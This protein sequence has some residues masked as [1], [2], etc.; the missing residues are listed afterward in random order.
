MSFRIWKKGEGPAGPPARDVSRAA[1]GA[2][3][4]PPD[5]VAA[6]GSRI[7]TMALVAAATLAL[8][9]LLDRVFSGVR[10]GS[11]AMLWLIGVAGAIAASLVMAWI[12]GRQM[13]DSEKLLDAALVYEVVMG[14]FLSVNIHASAV[15]DAVPRGWSAVAVWT[16]AYPLIVPATRG[17]V[18]LATVATAVMDPL[19]LVVQVAAGN[20][21][22]PA[23][24]VWLMFLPTAVAAIA[25]IV[26]SGI[27]Y[28]MNVE[29][30][31]GH[32]MGSY[33]LEELLGSGGMGEVW[34]ASH[35]LLARSA[36]IKLI[37]PDSSGSDG[38]E[39][40]K[41]FE[42]EVQAAA[43]LQSPH[44]VNIYDFGTTEDGTFYYVMELLEG[45][46][47]ETLVARF[48]PVPAER[49]VHILI[50]ACHSLAEAHQGG[51]IHRDV[52]PANIYVCR[53]GLEW[54]FVKILDF[55]LVKNT[56]TETNERQLTRAGVLAG[57]PGYMAPEMGMGT[58]DL[59]WRAD[60]YALGA[61][62]YWLVTG[63][64]L[65]DP[66]RPA[67]QIIMDHVQKVPLPP[68]RRTSNFVPPRLEEILMSCLQKDPNNRPQTM[69]ELA[70][71]LRT[72]PLEREWTDDRARRWWLAH[73]REAQDVVVDKA[74]EAKAST[75]AQVRAGAV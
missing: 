43:G 47:V 8:F 42:R 24:A 29:A 41:R 11:S 46:D 59:D 65:F 21:A 1:S 15:T 4:L 52:K 66:K 25:A 28:Q 30:E 20:P 13:L 6:S 26:V 9:A 39:S 67:M 7:T 12:S 48:G 74:A 5:L 71:S 69:Q 70:A 38:R 58:A 40:I 51:L 49:V 10:P 44:T 33:H 45:F 36:A 34:K 53:Y 14:L 2:A 18:I 22:P 60:I 63:E 56:A 3:V 57:T 31:K 54:D 64:T 72:V 32:E 27:V 50:Q 73:A 19:G 62:G 37:R 23:P 35:R 16:L 75:P 61:V 17:K 55:G 68:S